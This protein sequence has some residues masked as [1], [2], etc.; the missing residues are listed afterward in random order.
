MFYQTHKSI[1]GFLKVSFIHFYSRW[2]LAQGRIEEAEKIVRKIAK[3][4]GNPLPPEFHLIPPHSSDKNG[5]NNAGG[6][7]AFLNLFKTPNMRMKTLIIYYCWFTTAMIY[8]G[9]TLN[10]NNVGSLF[11]IY[12]FGKGNYT[13][14][15]YLQTSHSHWLFYICYCCVNVIII[16]CNGIK[17]DSQ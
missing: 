1:S 11:Q 9:L 15:K 8:Y 13:H 5:K 7:F 2:L 4:N 17:L 12:C 16:T 14:C 6:I 3:F 10:S